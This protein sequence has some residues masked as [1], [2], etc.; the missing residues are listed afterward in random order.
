MC[1]LE[2]NIVCKTTLYSL[3]SQ[4]SLIYFLLTV[5][6]VAVGKSKGKCPLTAPSQQL[7]NTRVMCGRPH[8]FHNLQ[9]LHTK[10]GPHLWTPEGYWTAKLA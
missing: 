6:L 1:L 7:A 4:M 9:L 2:D 5:V 3:I 10:A 8:L